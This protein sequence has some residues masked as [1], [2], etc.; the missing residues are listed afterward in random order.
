VSS[1]VSGS[2]R[3]LFA[4]E[5][6]ATRQREWRALALACRALPEWTPAW[7]IPWWRELGPGRLR[8]VA[9]TEEDGRIA[10]LGLFCETRAPGPKLLTALGRGYSPAVGLLLAPG[11][12]DL[13]FDL[14]AAALGPGP[15]V[16]VMAGTDDRPL[17]EAGAAAR[18]LAVSGR[19]HTPS[20]VVALD[21]LAA[22]VGEPGA[23]EAADAADAAAGEVRWA[24]D[25]RAE[26]AALDA[27]TRA[28]GFEPGPET[29]RRREHSFLVTVLDSFGRAGDL[30]WP[31]AADGDRGVA[32]SAWLV[33]GDR[34]S[35]WLRWPEGTGGPAPTADLA[36]AVTE[37]RRRGVRDVVVPALD[38]LG[39]T[40]QPMG[41]ETLL[42]HNRPGLR[43]LEPLAWAAV[44]GAS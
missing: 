14:L 23:A 31:V 9:A 16:L 27:L 28:L 34:A 15:A 10:G 24:V 12:E 20:R 44:K 35:L 4:W 30:V 40:G 33:H 32:T 3:V 18:G 22:A 1:P 11:R 13:A 37:L 21:D 36:G 17:L 42:V 6:L 39:R 41:S 5:D 19:P 2:V 43:R 38:P 25:P 26:P 8:A 29:A 7:C